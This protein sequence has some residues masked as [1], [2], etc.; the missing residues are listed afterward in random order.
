MNKT[1]IIGVIDR[2]KLLGYK[3]MKKVETREGLS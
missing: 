1:K 3:I 2:L